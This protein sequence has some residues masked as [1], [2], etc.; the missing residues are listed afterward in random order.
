MNGK[1]KLVGKIIMNGKWPEKWKQILSSNTG[2]LRLNQLFTEQIVNNQQQEYEMNKWPNSNSSFLHNVGSLDCTSGLKS[3]EW[4]H[5]NQLYS[6]RMVLWRKLDNKDEI[7]F[8]RNRGLCESERSLT[9]VSAGRGAPVYG[10]LSSQGRK[11]RLELVKNLVK[12]GEA[13]HRVPEQLAE[14]FR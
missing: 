4:R 2:L 11:S 1:N 3:R 12:Q 9:K 10:R 14:E 8:N 7:D 5:Q 13:N 6:W